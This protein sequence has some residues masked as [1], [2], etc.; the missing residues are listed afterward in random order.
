[1]VRVIG[2]GLEHLGSIPGRVM[3]KTQE[4]VLDATL[5]NTQHYKVGIKGKEKQSRESSRAFPNTLV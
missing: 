5:P 3:P 2:N 1:M 4:I